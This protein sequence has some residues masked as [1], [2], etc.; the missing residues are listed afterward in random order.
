[1]SYTPPPSY[2]TGSTSSWIGIIDAAVSGYCSPAPV[3]CP[4]PPC[5]VI[6]SSDCMFYVGEDL[7]NIGVNT[8]DTFTTILKKIEQITS[9]STDKNFV[10]TQGT[11]SSVWTIFHNL[12]KYPSVTVKDNGNT[13]QEG[14]VE[15]IDS[16]N[17]T[18]TFSAGFA[19]K[20]YLN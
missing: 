18:I 4:P 20:A 11:V 14:Y 6:L 2:L 19:G 16:N 15:Y 7:P 12:D 9:I 5:P 3:P 8:Q 10:F 17:L 1:M 13:T